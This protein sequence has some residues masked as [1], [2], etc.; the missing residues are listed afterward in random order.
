[1]HVTLL[2]PQRAPTVDR[3]ARNLEPE[4]PIATITA[5]WREREP[6]DTEL[7][8]LL[9][10]RSINLGLYRRW[11]HVLEHD[12]EFRDAGLRL[13][14]T[15]DE[16][17]SLYLIRLENALDAVVA[18]Q[19]G[20][21]SSRRA[22]EVADAIAAV[23][24]LDDR[25]VSLV[26]DIYSE[27]YDTWRPQERPVIVAHRQ[28]VADVVRAA[29]A[30]VM[31]GGHVGVLSSTLRL[32]DVLVDLNCPVIAWSAGAMALTDR[33]VLFHDRTPQGPTPAE[34]LEPG[35]A[36]IGDIVALPHARTRLLIEDVDR[37]AVFARRFAPARCV[38]LEPDTRFTLDGAG[39]SL[40]DG[41]R[42]VDEDG[43]IRTIGAP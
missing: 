18:L 20:D 22:G 32:F 39:G 15:L 42:F 38:V 23:R 5:G 10:S 29:V 30:L 4:G 1:M 28:Q 31:T 37:M 8:S 40:P 26:S 2:G 34:I 41:V 25:H 43:R 36:L 12:P 11:L 14:E 9:G 35:M 6:E 17:Q 33:I 3:V 21:P 19:H 7:D 24:A 27:F 13:R 16:I